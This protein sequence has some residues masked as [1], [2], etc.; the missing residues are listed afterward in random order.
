MLIATASLSALLLLSS[1]VWWKA[2]RG[3][4]KARSRAVALEGDLKTTRL[5]VEALRVGE[6]EASWAATAT[7]RRLDRNMVDLGKASHEVERLEGDLDELRARLGAADRDLERLRSEHDDASSRVIVLEGELDRS[8]SE[9]AEAADQL[10]SLAGLE[11]R[12]LV[13]VRERDRLSAV[14]QRGEQLEAE[15]AA[16]GRVHQQLAAARAESA[17]LRA[18]LASPTTGGPDDIDQ[19]ESLRSEI[20]DLRSQLTSAD[21]RI[22]E[23]GEK[24]RSASLQVTDLQTEMAALPTDDRLIASTAARHDLEQQL[25][26]LRTTRSAE[27]HA[28]AERISRLERLHGEIAERDRRIAELEDVQPPEGGGVE[29][30]GARPPSYA[31]WDLELRERITASVQE[32]TDRLHSQV[33]HLRLVIAEKERLLQRE[34]QP[35]APAGGHIPVTSINGIGP[36]I[37]AILVR[38]GIASVGAIAAL[39]DADIE[40]LGKK[41]PVYPGRIRHDDW[42]GQAQALLD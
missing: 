42:V 35:V 20:G 11:Q 21:R 31:E 1:F 10:T 26:A 15:L 4:R 30:E 38:E 6:R 34:P 17:T 5:A 8:R 13:V 33:E 29:A 12:L 25:E 40:R 7:A 37:A 27:R 14:V 23:A 2:Q 28:S 22:A 41:M 18:R 16:L 19:V 32:A 24:L 36:V 9:T 39:S 3:R